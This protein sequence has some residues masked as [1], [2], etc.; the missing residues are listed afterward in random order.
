MS[1]RKIAYILLLSA[2]LLLCSCGYRDVSLQRVQ[3]MGALL[4][5]YDAE[6]SL[7]AGGQGPLVEI[8]KQAAERI[9]V[10][11]PVVPAESHTWQE[12]LTRRDI[13]VMLDASAED[14]LTLG[15][16]FT[17]QA[18]LVYRQKDVPDWSGK[19][20][21]VLD[22]G[23][24]AEAAKVMD[25]YTYAGFS[26][27]SDVDMLIDDLNAGRV[28]AAILS[29]FDYR[30]IRDAGYQYETAAERPVYLSLRRGDAALY[31]ALQQALAQMAAEGVI[32]DILYGN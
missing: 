2:V 32:D 8:V 16:V 14:N 23:L 9:G 19:I 6:G 4:A 5:G 10:L 17:T 29:R 18:L 15:P 12:M 31:N 27:Y 21:G 28:D 1:I 7:T 22:A 26:Y 25:G 3:D 20:V 13:D 11:A 30:L 24:C